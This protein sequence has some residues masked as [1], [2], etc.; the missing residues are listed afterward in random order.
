MNCVV[1]EI[2]RSSVRSLAPEIAFPKRGSIRR[3]NRHLHGQ[4]LQPVQKQL[5]KRLFCHHFRRL[6]SHK[7]LVFTTCLIK[8][9]KIN[10]T[11][12]I[13]GFSISLMDVGPQYHEQIDRVWIQWIARK[14]DYSGYTDW[15]SITQFSNDFMLRFEGYAL[16]L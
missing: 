8:Y 7:V 9:Y 14:E 2:D 11:G 13:G 10:L 3:L 12:D 5:A 16:S 1:S 6:N 15:D 4:R